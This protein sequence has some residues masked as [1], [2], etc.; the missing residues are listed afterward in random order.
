MSRFLRFIVTNSLAGRPEMLKESV[1][2]VHV[3]DR[4][5]G[6]DSKADPVVRTEARRLRRKLLEYAQ[7]HPE[8]ALWIDLPIGGY[9]PGFRVRAAGAGPAKVEEVPERPRNRA[10]LVVIVALPVVLLLAGGAWLL[11]HRTPSYAAIHV[12]PFTTAPGYQRA[13]DFSP[14]GDLIAYSWSGPDGGVKEIWIQSVAGGPPRQ[15]THGKLNAYRPS[16]SPDGRHIAFVQRDDQD[17]MSI[18]TVDV[19]GAN[20]RVVAQ[21]ISTETTTGRVDWSP[22][23]KYLVTSDRDTPTSPNRII[24]ITL[25]TGGRRKVTAPAASGPAITTR[26]SL[27]MDS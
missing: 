19:S 13:P 25:A 15:L 5:V 22:D 21:V 27:P 12:R 16:W 24:L 4:E 18:C 6:Y 3:F 1:I 17:H 9:V 20:Q 11:S 23:G 7:N 2:G 10:P 8:D 14:D 26:S